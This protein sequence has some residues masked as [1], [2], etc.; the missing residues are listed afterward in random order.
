MKSC[1][2]CRFISVSLTS[3]KKWKCKQ[4]GKIKRFNVPWLHGFLCKYFKAENE[5]KT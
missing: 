2:T 4:F 1:N 5:E 3:D